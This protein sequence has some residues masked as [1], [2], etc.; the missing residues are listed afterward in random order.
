MVVLCCADGRINRFAPSSEV[1][2]ESMRV[3]GHVSVLGSLDVP[4][5][6]VDGQSGHLDL[7]SSAALSHLETVYVTNSGWITLFAASATARW[8]EVTYGTLNL[9]TASQLTVEEYLAVTGGTLRGGT[10]VVESQNPSNPAR[11]QLDGSTDVIQLD[12]GNLILNGNGEWAGNIESGA[13][14]SFTITGVLSVTD[15]NDHSL[16]GDALPG[17]TLDLIVDGPGASITKTNASAGET[18]IRACY[19]LRN[20]GQ[21]IE[22]PGAG[23][24]IVTMVCT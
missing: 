16:V 2:A 5:L 6:E 14:A 22:Q 3:N 12:R 18:T 19:D 15:Y 10:I 20:G 9:G 1:I 24:L 7:E 13:G 21:T 23:S 8:V 17:N 4:N 11:L